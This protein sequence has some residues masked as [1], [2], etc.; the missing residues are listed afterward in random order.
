MMRTVVI[1]VMC[2]ALI[3]LSACQ[4]ERLDKLEKGNAE[5]KMQFQKQRS[6]SNL[7][8]Q[9][10][11]SRDATAWF[12]ENWPAENDTI[13]LTNTNHYNRKRTKREL[14]PERMIHI[15]WDS[16]GNRFAGAHRKEG[17]PAA[18]HDIR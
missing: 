15:V 1:T 2:F 6:V 4:N 16:S 17:S 8:L 10:K 12:R 7:E 9:S 11:C 5:L 3:F 18:I 14:R 13:R